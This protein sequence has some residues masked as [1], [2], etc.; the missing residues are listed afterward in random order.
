MSKCKC[1]RELN[2]LQTYQCSYCQDMERRHNELVDATE[3]QTEAE[4]AA[5]QQT[6]EALEE[7]NRQI[8]LAS[9]AAAE[10]TERA[11]YLINNPGDYECPACKMKSLKRD[12]SRCPK[13]Q[14][15]VN[16]HYWED[17]REE[18]RLAEE[19]AAKK[20]RIEEEEH[21]KWLASPEYAMEQKQKKLAIAEQSRKAAE[22]LQAVRKNNRVTENVV[23]CICGIL[24][25]LVALLIHNVNPDGEGLAAVIGAATFLGIV[26]FV[27]GG[28]HVAP[29]FFESEAASLCA[30]DASP[31]NK[32]SIKESNE[33]TVSEWKCGKC[34]EV[35]EGTFDTCWKCGTC[36]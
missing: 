15:K 32:K 7:H 27:L 34:G 35:L 23:A 31:D 20:Q 1:G 12:A 9:E 16:E 4:E 13:C 36:R 25:F 30:C 3:E 22:K 17:I 6:R 2:F 33:M 10:A 19:R 28:V 14:E 5:S 21:R 8:E 18:E 24:G 26:G 11:A 29:F